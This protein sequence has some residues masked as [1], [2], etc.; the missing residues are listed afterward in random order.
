[1]INNKN[2]S[3]F[4]KVIAKKT[5][6]SVEILNLVGDSLIKILQYPN[7]EGMLF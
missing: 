3:Q 7:R 6:L 4:L 1:M 5:R 2:R